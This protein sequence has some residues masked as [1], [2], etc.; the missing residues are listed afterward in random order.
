MLPTL[1]LEMRF[2][3]CAS[4]QPELSSKSSLQNLLQHKFGLCQPPADKPGDNLVEQ[5]SKQGFSRHRWPFPSAQLQ[6]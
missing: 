6:G 5:Y 3:I 4:Q 1:V 2:Q